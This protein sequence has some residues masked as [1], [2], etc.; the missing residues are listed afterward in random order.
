MRLLGF[1]SLLLPVACAYS[2]FPVISEV[3]LTTLIWIY[4]DHNLCEDGCNIAYKYFKGQMGEVAW[5]YKEVPGGSMLEA[6]CKESKC[7]GCGYC[8]QKDI[9]RE[10]RQE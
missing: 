10:I 7:S 8:R 3:H 4:E 1:F 2:T 5:F 6:L 9:K